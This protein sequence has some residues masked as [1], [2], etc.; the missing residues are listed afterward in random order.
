MNN[1]EDFLKCMEALYDS[2]KADIKTIP[3]YIRVNMKFAPINE[4]LRI[5]YL[6][7][8]KR[9]SKEIMEWINHHDK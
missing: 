3:E 1:K 5:F 7:V 2:L 4:D 6:V 8:D 9:I